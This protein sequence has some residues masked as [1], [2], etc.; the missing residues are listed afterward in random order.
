MKELFKL[1]IKK[2]YIFSFVFGTIYS[3]ADYGQAFALSHFGTSPLTLDK[4]VNLTICIIVF[5]RN[6]TY[7]I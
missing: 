5:R 2:L 4:I 1:M 3:I 7:Y 6:Y